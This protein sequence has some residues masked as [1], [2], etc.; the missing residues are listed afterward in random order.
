MIAGERRVRAAQMAGLDAIPA[1]VRDLT[2]Q[3]AEDIQ[4]AENIQRK[5]LTNMELARRLQK[6]LEQLGSIDAVMAKRNKSRLG[7]QDSVA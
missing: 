7:V 3:Q 6:D 1:M 2:D 5:N 4:A